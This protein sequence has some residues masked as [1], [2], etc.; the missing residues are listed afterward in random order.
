[1]YKEQMRMPLLR[2]LLFLTLV[3]SALGAI[4][5][6]S[7]KS[8]LSQLPDGTLSGDIYSN[9]AL[10][11]RYEVPPGWIAVA[12][13]KDPVKIDDRD[14]DGPVNQCSKVLLW[15]RAP[16][17][18]PEQNKAQFN[19]TITLLAIDPHCFPGAKFPKSL[20]DRK[21]VQEFARK[22]VNSFSHTAF[23]SRNGA[24]IDAD[25][26]NGKLAIWLTGADLIN[27]PDSQ[28]VKEPLRVNRLLGL[29]E[30]NGYWIAWANLAD[31]PTK[32]QLQKR[33]DLQI[34]VKP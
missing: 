14:P 21:R 3:F 16:E 9:R 4:C 22:I 2:N 25:I 23:I 17:Q 32:A 8:K 19:S 12:D 24:D 33:N 1:V 6:G 34:A 11:L 5:L 7:P 15:L 20:K 27:A 31:D 10:G 18:D 26:Q 28:A 13:P 30:S 29:V